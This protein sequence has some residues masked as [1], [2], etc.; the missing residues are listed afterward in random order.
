MTFQDTY[1]V[2]QVVIRL[3]IM[4]KVLQNSQPETQAMADLLDETFTS[5]INVSFFICLCTYINGN[6]NLNIYT[7][8]INK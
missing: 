5:K 1:R 6:T 4:V 8:K 7:K 2:Y 3:P